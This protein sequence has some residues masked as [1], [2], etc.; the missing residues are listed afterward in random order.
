MWFFF[1][2]RK[3]PSPIIPPASPLPPEIIQ[4]L[5]ELRAH[6]FAAIGQGADVSKIPDSHLAACYAFGIT[7][8]YEAAAQLS[9]L[10]KSTIKNHFARPVYV[11]LIKYFARSRLHSEGFALGVNTLVTIM[12]DSGASPAARVAAVKAMRDWTAQD[13]ASEAPDGKPLQEMTIGEL[14]ALVDKLQRDAQ[15][16]AKTIDITPDKQEPAQPT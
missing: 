11:K 13:T 1:K 15:M 2:G 14:A 5:P 6:A 16:Q 10:G 4:Q 12:Q 8:D 9:R 7:G 3:M